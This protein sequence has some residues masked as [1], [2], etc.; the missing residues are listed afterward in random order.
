MRINLKKKSYLYKLLLLAL[1]I[2]MTII[3]CYGNGPIDNIVGKDKKLTGTIRIWCSERSKDS[4]SNSF[5]LFKK[6]YPE[7]ELEITALTKEEIKSD[8]SKED[9]SQ[10][11]LPHIIEVAS[12]D[13][14]N[15]VN[16]YPEVFVTVDKAMDKIKDKILPWKLEEVTYDKKLYAFPWD[17][18]PKVLIYNKKLADQYKISSF[19]IKT[20]LEFSD[21]GILLKDQ[22]LG[23]VKL[24]ALRENVDGNLYK[25][26]LRQFRKALY[27]NESSITLPEEENKH[28]LSTIKGMYREEMVY[29]LKEGEDPVQVLK[30]GKALCILGDPSIINRINKDAELNNIQWEVQNLPAFEYGG[31]RSVHGEGNAFMLTKKTESKEAAQDFLNFLLTDVDSVTY[32]LKEAGI[33][34]SLPVLYNLPEFNSTSSN[35]QGIRLWRFMAE[36]SKEE[37][38]IL[39]DHRYEELEK[40]LIQM[41]EEALGGR[42]VGVLTTL[43]EEELNKKS[44]GEAGD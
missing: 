3:G 41:E 38:A 40:K 36:Q 44:N 5:M 7:L 25:S 16:S 2:I 1:I 11:D 23:Q 13:I 24:I 19:E 35:Y 34:P 6:E 37:V 12:Y 43:L 29:T 27:S 18:E 17:T 10:E 9:I 30:E 15:M 8:L 28:V 21:L 39:Y 22:S 4:I 14:A 31:K 32:S 26:M 20:W 42:D 33:I